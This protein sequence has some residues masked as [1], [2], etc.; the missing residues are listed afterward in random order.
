MNNRK[1]GLF[2]AIFGACCWGISGTIAQ[3]FFQQTGLSTFW[4]T[5]ARLLV[6]GCLLLLYVKL[7]KGSKIFAIWHDKYAAG[8]L[9]LFAFIGMVLS[10]FTYFMAIEKGNAA[11]ATILQFTGPA[12]IIMTLALLNRQWPRRIEII[13]IL[14]AMV[15]TFLLVTQGHPGSLSLS[16]AALAWGLLAGVSQATYT[17][18]PVKL[19]QKYDPALVIGWA[20]T[21]GSVIFWPALTSSKISQLN[22]LHLAMLAFIILFG[23]LIAYLFYLS[24]LN[25]LMPAITSILS[26]F[27]PLVATLL[28]ISFLGVRFNLVGIIG[29]SLVLLTAG[30]QLFDKPTV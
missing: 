2:L 1:H 14:M 15:G 8:R 21:L 28:A 9:F 29:G 27:E 5:G 26:A 10:Q 11:T 24:S 4:L 23:T 25:Y 16:P 30:L 20:M 17:L 3:A 7:A 18:T 22:W 6:A 12:F 19:L 13:S